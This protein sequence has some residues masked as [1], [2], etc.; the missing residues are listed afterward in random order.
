MSRRAHA[1]EEGIRPWMSVPYIAHSQGVPQKTLWEALGIPP[2]GHDHRPLAR[3]AREKK[4]RVEDLIA[5]LRKA[6]GP[7]RKTPPDAP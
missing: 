4:K 3:I 2:H 5:K 6:I 7:A 1:G